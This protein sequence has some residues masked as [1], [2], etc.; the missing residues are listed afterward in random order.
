MNSNKRLV[1][2]TLYLYLRM[3][4]VMAVGFYAT[5]E[6]LKLLGVVDYGI[7][8]VVGGIVAMFSFVNSTLTT[9][10]QRYFSIELAKG[11]LK[12][13]NQWFCLNITTFSI[14]IAIFI[15]VSETIGLWF[16]NTQLT[17]PVERLFAANVVYQ[18][19][20]LTFC[21][22]F[23]CIP[24]SALIVAHEKM[25]AFAYISIVEA[26][27]KLAIVFLLSIITWDRLILYAILMCLSSLVITS[28][29]M[30]YNRKHFSESKYNL[31]W[32]KTECLELIGFSG[33][34]LLGTFSTVIRS[35]GINILINL[36]FNPAVNAARAVSFQ[37]YHAIS[38]LSSNFFVAVKPQ[39]YKNYANG[40]Y[41][42]LH[43]LIFRSTIICSYL[44]A[45]V[46]FPILSNT[47]YLISLWL[48]EI[49]EY[50]VAFTQLVLING[51]IDS[52]NGPTIASALATG[53]IRTYQ[54]IVSSINL[55]NFPLA[56]L[57]LYNGAEPTVTVLISIILSLVSVV[58]RGY[59][60][61]NMI[62]FPYTR[63]LYL[64]FRLVMANLFIW[65]G[66]YF[67]IYNKINNFPIIIVT[68]ILILIVITLTYMFLVCDKYERNNILLFLKR[69]C[70]R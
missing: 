42:E 58:V 3:L 39:I 51:L 66:I 23:F 57:A 41:D 62:E 44:I 20:I 30:I 13:L 56:Y 24:Y 6:I 37:L 63:Y 4:V 47:S 2:N 69:K 59:L 15:L 8:N 68:S 14:F 50:T 38:Q 46:V 7:Y 43:K 18:L 52:T 33:W 19:S 31:Y 22:H 36:F 53:R 25:N 29:Y 55:A 12:R 54:L 11:D 17:I 40:E 16:I 67:T 10:S 34:H 32:N 21:I 28:S 65:G 35:Q 26:F 9:S 48:K 27:F 49:P 60:L 70:R 45:L 5:R 61:K 1:K 64:F